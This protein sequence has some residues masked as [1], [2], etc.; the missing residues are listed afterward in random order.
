MTE[1]VGTTLGGAPPRWKA[2]VLAAR[3]ATLTASLG[4]VM[5][6]SAIA[7]RQGAFHPEAFVLALLAAVAIQIGTNLANDYFDHQKGAD[8]PDRLGPARASAQGWLPPHAVARGAALSFLAAAVLGLGL[9]PFGGWP[10]AASGL[11]GIVAGVAY[12]GGPRPLGYLG[13]GELFVFVYFGL[14]AV[15]GMVLVHGASVSPDALVAGC[16]EGALAAAIL[17]VNN[18]R[19]RKTDRRAGKRTLAVRFGGRFARIEYAALVAFAYVLV[20]GAVLAGVAPVAW[21][22]A[23]AT[24][25]F[26]VL[27]AREVLRGEGAELNRALARTARLGFLF[28]LVLAVGALP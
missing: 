13:L 7:R 1:A 19:D 27:V 4:P 11:S 12:T 3:P 24:L 23:A 5:L 10:I 2:W 6:G 20:V 22:A 15:L 16:A 26:S 18:L 14:L 28:A 9:L 17:V 25:P 8:R 21:L